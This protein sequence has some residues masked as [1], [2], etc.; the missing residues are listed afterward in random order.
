[1]AAEG[2]SDRMV[3]DMGVCMKHRCVIEFL[4]AEDMAPI[5]IHQCLLNSYVDQPVGVST[6][7][8]WV[9]WFSSGSSKVPCSGYPCAAVTP[10]KEECLNQLI[11][12]N[13]WITTRELRTK[14][15]IS[16]NALETMV[17]MLEYHKACSM[18][19]P[20]MLTQKQK[21]HCMQVCQ[22]LWNQ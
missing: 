10:R 18:W 22:D 17:A 6:V 15:N 11:H 2:Q 4:H 16:F 1:M 20:Q 7:K 8:H 3:S 5:D 9:V 13:W 21:E 12:V 19:I 14:L